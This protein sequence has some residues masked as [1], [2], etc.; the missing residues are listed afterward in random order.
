VA[1]VKQIG[2][3]CKDSCNFSPI[4]NGNVSQDPSIGLISYVFESF[5]AKMVCVWKE[6]GIFAAIISEK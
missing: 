2:G 5:F 4:C 1:N 3:T 6:S